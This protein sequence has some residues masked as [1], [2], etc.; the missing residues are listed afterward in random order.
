MAARYRYVIH[1]EVRRRAPLAVSIFG[2][3]LVLVQT[4]HSAAF[5]EVDA[6]AYRHYHSRHVRDLAR[7]IHAR[8]QRLP[9]AYRTTAAEALQGLHMSVSAQAALT[10]IGHSTFVVRIGRITILT[11]PVFSKY[12]SPLP[13]FGPKRLVPP[14]I[15]FDNLPPIDAVLLSHSHYDHTDYPSLR[16]LARRSGRTIVYAPPGLKGLLKRAGFGNI[17]IHRPDQRSRLGEISLVSIAVPHPTGRNLHG[18][19]DPY[20]FSWRI[21][22]RSVRV[23]FAGDTAQSPIFRHVRQTYGPTDIALLP[24]GS[25]E[26][27]QFERRNHIK[28]EHALAIAKDLGATT[29]IPM[30]WGTFAMTP[31]PITEPIVRFRHQASRGIRKVTLKIGETHAVRDRKHS[32]RKSNDTNREKAGAKPAQTDR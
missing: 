7:N 4:Q 8:G 25:Y 24:I 21:D 29:V 13:P 10:W 20:S 28:P 2:A 32:L 19:N 15:L 31:E 16:R 11:D 18:D 14:G 23:F 1:R 12:V 17:I 26:P 30:H 6:K 27:W 22:G 9:E 5:D 3:A